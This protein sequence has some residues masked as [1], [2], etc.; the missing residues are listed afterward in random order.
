MHS[1]LPLGGAEYCHP[2]WYGKTRMV[3]LPEGKNN[4]EDMCNRLDRILTCDRQTDEQTDGRTDILSRHTP[5]YMRVY[6]RRIL[7]VHDVR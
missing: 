4:F 2:V 5:R 6:M 3:A 7:C 1:T